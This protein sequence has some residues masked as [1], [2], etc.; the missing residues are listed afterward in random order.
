MPILKRAI[1][2]MCCAT[3][4]CTPQLALAETVGLKVDVL[5]SLILEGPKIDDL[6]ISELSGLA[7]DRQNAQL[8]AVSD[9]GRLFKFALDLT[10]DRIAS[11]EPL[12]GHELVDADGARIR[13]SGFN[14]EGIAMAG[15]GT[16]AIVS[17]HGPRIAR[18]ST[19]GKWLDD[20]QVPA[21]LSDPAAQRSEKD[22]LE[23]VAIHPE[24]GLLTLP[25]EPLAAEE[26]T[27]HTIHAENGTTLAFDTTNIGTTSIK[28][29]EVLSDGRIAMIER[30][31]S[32][33]D[34]SLLPFLRILD[35]ANCNADR[36]CE[37][38]VA[39]IDVPGITDA[40]F[41]GITQVS[42]DLILIVSDDKIDSGRRSVF[43]LL[44]FAPASAG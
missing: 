37:T 2:T 24:L 13:N 17:E 10:G 25:E 29:L 19:D 43:G 14:A 42:D 30:D 18:F 32:A 31:V 40:D 35:P 16:L 26:R 21:A 34:D 7:Y 1:R 15:D 12:A 39:R 33:T 20:M 22:G 4:I 6:K 38:Q 9:K 3:V 23:A 11:L 28:G 5:D 41:E 36:M 44:R 8:I 27:T